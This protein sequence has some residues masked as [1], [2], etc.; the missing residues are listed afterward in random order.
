MKRRGAD[1]PE[2][3]EM[4][5]DPDADGVEWLDEDGD[6]DEVG[7]RD[8]V[9]PAPTTRHRALGSLLAA[10]AL[11][12][13]VAAGSNAVYRHDL[14]ADAAAET[15]SNELILAVPASLGMSLPDLGGVGAAG[16][17]IQ[18]PRTEIALPVVNRGPEPVTLLP[19]ATL[20]GAGVT[21]WSADVRGGVVLAPGQSTVLRGYVTVDC[22]FSGPDVGVRART[23]LTLRARTS[24]GGLGV[25]TVTYDGAEGSVRDRVCHAQFE[26]LEHG[27]PS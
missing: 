13:A 1:G 20:L 12:A 14:A 22:V 6:A 17:W 18:D 24:G 10:G 8:P 15:A 26:P 16:G 2:D 27:G 4:F 5:L 25:S 21:A 11:V 9:L 19:G 7:A 23:S 3:P